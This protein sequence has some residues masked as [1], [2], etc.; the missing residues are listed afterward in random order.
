MLRLQTTI[1]LSSTINLVLNPLEHDTASYRHKENV[2][3]WS[4]ARDKNAEGVLGSQSDKAEHL[5]H[6]LAIASH[7]NVSI[8]QV[9]RK[10]IMLLPWTPMINQSETFLPVR[11]SP[12]SQRQLTAQFQNRRRGT[13]QI[14]SVQRPGRTTIERIICYAACT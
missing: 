1:L 2:L 3:R 10:V 6:C 9:H 11:N 5:A 14:R 13:S 7:L 12:R 4:K 8:T